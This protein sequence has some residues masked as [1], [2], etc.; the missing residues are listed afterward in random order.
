[1]ETQLAHLSVLQLLLALPTPTVLMDFV[2][3]PWSL[4]LATVLVLSTTI[5]ALMK[6]SPSLNA[7]PQTHAP[8]FLKPLTHAL[9]KNAHQ[10]TRKLT[11]VHALS[12]TQFWENA[13][14]TNTVEVSQFGLSLSSLLSPS[15]LFWP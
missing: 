5:L 12:Q 1:V 13:S 7:S 9:N 8:C 2:F 15:F 4:D 11:H 6:V 10:T 3:V 14:T